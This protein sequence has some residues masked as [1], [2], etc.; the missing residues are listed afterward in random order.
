MKPKMLDVVTGCVVAAV[1]LTAL[2]TDWVRSG[3]LFRLGAIT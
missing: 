1:I 2:V 3:G